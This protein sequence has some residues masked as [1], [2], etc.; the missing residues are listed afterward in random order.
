M[1]ALR[2]MRSQPI[3]NLDFSS[4]FPKTL[5]R[6]PDEIWHYIFTFLSYQDQA[7]VALTCRLW[8][9]I[10][11][12]FFDTYKMQMFDCVS[13]IWSDISYLHH[14]PEESLVR[15]NT[16]SDFSQLNVEMLRK[17]RP[18]KS[19]K[20]FQLKKKIQNMRLRKFH[21]LDV[22]HPS[23]Q[24]L[25]MLHLIE[26]AHLSIPETL[27]VLDFDEDYLH[28]PGFKYVIQHIVFSENLIYTGNVN[29]NKHVDKVL[30]K[31]IVLVAI[32]SGVFD[33]IKK[34][35]KLDQAM[36]LCKSIDMIGIID[37]FY[38]NYYKNEVG[39]MTRIDSTMQGFYR[40]NWG[41]IFFETEIN[42]QDAQV[43]AQSIQ[44]YGKPGCIGF[45]H[46][47]DLDNEGL[48]TIGLAIQQSNKNF[49]IRFSHTQ[50][51]VA[52]VKESLD[53]LRSL[54]NLDLEIDYD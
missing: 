21:K 51:F 45:Y 5:R 3:K 29:F 54:Q 22:S 37:G 35:Q 47:S 53:F 8:K 2:S 28:L 15:Y 33:S 44:T 13:L 42:N 36:I 1:L 9:N 34:I 40:K 12:S 31:K 23:V 17:Y 19:L 27:H 46:E 32:A 7:K 6:V 30:S 14:L 43:L 11:Q 4:A 20:T 41:L 48:Y 49:R 24:L 50:E 10:T 25:K 16:C 38:T 52:S 18:S 26:N 39:L